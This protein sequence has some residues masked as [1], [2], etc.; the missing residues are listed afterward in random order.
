MRGHQLMFARF[1]SCRPRRDGYGS[2]Q[3]APPYALAMLAPR[4][5]RAADGSAGLSCRSRCDHRLDLLRAVADLCQNSARVL[6]EPRRRHS[7]L[8]HATVKYICYPGA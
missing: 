6:A 5:V 3:I 8:A 2:G 1:L 4:V 7:V